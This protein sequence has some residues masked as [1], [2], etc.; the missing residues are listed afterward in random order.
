MR[1]FVHLRGTHRSTAVSDETTPAR[2]G[3][4]MLVKGELS[5]DGDMVIEGRVEGNINAPQ[6]LVTVGERAKVEARIVA[7][8]VIVAGEV[9]GTS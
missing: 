8:T 9:R 5:G 4:S 1:P 2:I 7:R 3:K 6:N